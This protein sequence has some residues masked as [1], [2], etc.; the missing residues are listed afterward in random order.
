MKLLSKKTII[1]CIFAVFLLSNINI[2]FSQSQNISRSGDFTNFAKDA[3]LATITIDQ[4]KF[5]ANNVIFEAGS[6][7]Q[8]WSNVKAKYNGS[9]GVV[10]YDGVT[11]G[12]NNNYFINPGNFTITYKDA[13]IMSDGTRKNLVVSFAN[14]NFSTIPGNEEYKDTP[15]IFAAASTDFT[16]NGVRRPIP[17]LYGKSS[18]GKHFGFRSNLMTIRVEDVGSADTFLCTVEGINVNRRAT[19]NGWTSFQNLANG[20][21]NEYFSEQTVV[22]SSGTIYIPTGAKMVIDEENRSFLALNRNENGGANAN[23]N[24]Y[25]TGFANLANAQSGF[26]AK[27]WQSGP[28]K[29]R[30]DSF[31]LTDNI[32]YTIASSSGLNGTIVTGKSGNG[33]GLY[34]GSYDSAI[35][36]PANFLWDP[37]NAGKGPRMYDVPVGKPVTYTMTPNAGYI[38]D[39]LFINGAE[40]TAYE[41]VTDGSGNAEYYTYTFPGTIGNDN[42]QSIHV[43]WKKTFELQFVKIW[44]DYRNAAGER[45]NPLTITLSNT[46][47]HSFTPRTVDVSGDAGADHWTYTFSGLTG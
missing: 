31:I 13:A 30:T 23:N 37:A 1:L 19:G 18:A 3:D 8:T 6:A 35:G 43:T 20:A 29:D 14:N 2:V 34:G 10:Y 9:N 40:T 12:K 21:A 38:I 28:A 44:D 25:E 32:T 27:M 47:D 33:S 24:S 17:V 4:N 36:Y 41:T 45:P 39:K 5:R 22:L 26:R 46:S 16:V 11:M 7:G 15:Y 42:N